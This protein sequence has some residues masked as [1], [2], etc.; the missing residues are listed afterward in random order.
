MAPTAIA[1]DSID[2]LKKEVFGPI[3]H[4]IRFKQKDLRITV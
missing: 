4:V 3:L 1:I 2:A